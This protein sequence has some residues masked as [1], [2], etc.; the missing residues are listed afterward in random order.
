MFTKHE[1]LLE[2][3]LELEVLFHIS[4]LGRGAVLYSQG[5]KTAATQ[6]SV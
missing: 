4:S 2:A 5:S 3:S 6:D 1:H